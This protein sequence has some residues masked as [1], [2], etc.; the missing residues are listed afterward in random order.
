MDNILVLEAIIGNLR[1]AITI[2]TT[3]SLKVDH[4]YLPI[5]LHDLLHRNC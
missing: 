5:F 3:I 2:I 4:R 1:E